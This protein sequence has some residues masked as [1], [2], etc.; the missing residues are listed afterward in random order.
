MKKFIPIV[1]L[2]ALL[3]SHFLTVAQESVALSDLYLKG[4]WK[5]SCSVEVLDH[6]T[7]Q[8]CELCKFTID[9]QDK[10]KASVSEFEMEFGEDSIAIFRAG[11]VRVISYKRDKDNHSITFNDGNKEYHFR[12]FLDDER[13][14]L[15]DADGMLI[16]LKKAE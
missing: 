15:E 3:F 2:F 14:I 12:M 7:I 5:A 13:R 4:K 6:V 11:K 10:S 8:N 1:F 16:V 9:K